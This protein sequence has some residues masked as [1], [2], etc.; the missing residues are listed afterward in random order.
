MLRRIGRF[1]NG[2]MQVHSAVLEALT[3]DAMDGEYFRE[4]S[5]KQNDRICELLEQN[6]KLL[7]ALE[8]QRVWHEAEDKA[9]SKQPP[10]PDRN[11]RRMQHRERMDAIEAAVNAAVPTQR[12]QD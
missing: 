5:A 12:G 6:I 2:R 8:D 10:G 9:L 4:T 1:G 7:R 3:N 11:W